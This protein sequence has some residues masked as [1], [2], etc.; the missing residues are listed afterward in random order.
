MN[1]WVLI[2]VTFGINSITHPFTCTKK[3]RTNYKICSF[4]TFFASKFSTSSC[5]C[6]R[7]STSKTMRF[8]FFHKIDWQPINLFISLCIFCFLSYFYE[9]FS[10]WLFQ[11]KFHSQN[12]NSLI[13][14][15]FAL[16]QSITWKVFYRAAK[17]TKINHIMLVW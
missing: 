6:F 13:L 15:L 11:R 4:C 10:P 1:N 2:R 12:P 14:S 17:V 16:R 3:V 9:N 5:Y 7:K 8:F